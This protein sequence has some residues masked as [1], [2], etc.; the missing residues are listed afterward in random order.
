MNSSALRNLAARIKPHEILA[1]RSIT[2]HSANRLILFEVAE[3]CSHLGPRRETSAVPK[4]ENAMTF[5]H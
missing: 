5:A 3:N 2:C 1:S 4:T